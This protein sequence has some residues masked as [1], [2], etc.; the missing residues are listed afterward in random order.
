MG[1]HG[2]L[3]IYKAMLGL[4]LPFLVIKALS[5]AFSTPHIFLQM[6]IAF[7]IF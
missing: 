3:F 1:D 5:L 6:V 4:A 2:R 7:L